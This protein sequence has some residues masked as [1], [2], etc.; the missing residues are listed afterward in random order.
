[1][2]GRINRLA[3]T[4]ALL[5]AAS[6]LTACGSNTPKTAPL[7]GIGAANGSSA[8]AHPEWSK[9][10][11]TIGDNGGDGSRVLAQTTGAF[12]SAPYTV[13]FADF[14]YGPPLVQAAASG[15]IDLG[16]VGDVPP[17]TGAAQ[18]FGFKIVAVARSLSPTQPVEDIIVPKGSPIQTLAELKGKKVA[19]PQGSSAHGLAL[20]ALKSVGLTPNDVQLDFLSPAAGASAFASGKVDAW[21]IWNPQ[22]ALAVAQGARVLAKGLPPI[23]QTSNYYVASDK[24]LDDPNKRAALADVLQRLAA[25][26]AWGVKHPDDYAKAI[27]QEEGIPLPAAKAALPSM[28]TRVTAIGPADIQAEQQLGDAFLAAGQVK[29]KVDVAQIATNI[30]PADYDSS[31]TSGG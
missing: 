17:L 3:T 24:S 13:K 19:V 28:E 5:A 16:D 8:A 30:L 1:M 9:Y 11:F 4:V 20:L 21:S 10:S 2:S 14:T 26:F 29:K 27:S 6:A 23:D 25:E 18:E 7:S 12:K 22:A 15:A 31:K